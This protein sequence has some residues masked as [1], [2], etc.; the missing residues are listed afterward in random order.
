VRYFANPSTPS[1]REAITAGHLGMITTPKQGNLIPSGAE[2][3]ADNGCFGSGYVGDDRFIS[4]LGTL[5][6]ARFAV[7]PDVPFDMTASLARSRP[8]LGR[9]R[10]AGHLAALAAQN[11]SDRVTIP[12]DDLDVL[13]LGGDTEWKLGPQARDLAAE[14][15][16]R[17]KRVHMGRV[18]SLKRL[19]YADYIGCDSADGT[20]LTFGPDKNLPE[21][22]SWL[23]LVNGQTALF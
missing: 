7:A 22:L 3:C 10:A 5:P 2:V 17:G 6:P 23:R 20:F 1:V 16:T 21:L 13:F 15:R 19:K 4:W 11:G 8:M 12:W 14:A 9:I 18:N